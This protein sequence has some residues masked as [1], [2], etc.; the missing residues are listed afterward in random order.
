MKLQKTALSIAILAGLGFAGQTFA[1]DSA[2][3]GNKEADDLDT[4]VVVGI[5]GS[6]EKSQDAKREAKNRIEVV[7]SE[8]IGKM[9]DHN[10]ADSLQRIAGVNISAASANEGAFDEN[11]RVSMRGTSPSFTQ[12]LIDG[13]N[14]GSG[15][16]FVLNQSGTV[17]RSVSYS[18]LPSELVQKV[19]VIKSSEARLVEGGAVGNVNIVTR[20]PLNF[21]DGFTSHI[22]LGAV[23]ANLPGKTDPQLS[24]L[25]NWTN[26]ARSFGFMVQAFSEER[27][28]R[29][30]GQELLGYEQIQRFETDG[31]TPTALSLSNPDLVGVYYPTLIGSALFEQERKRTGGL[32]SAEFKPTDDFKFSLTGFTSRMKA[33]NYNRNYM[34][35]GSRILNRGQRINATTN[36]QAPAPGYVIRNNTLVSATFTP[37][38][39]RQYGIYD[40]ISRPGAESS[41]NFISGDFQW[42]VN[43]SF[44]LSG[45]LGT[46]TGRGKTPTQDVAEWDVGLGS[47][48]GWRLNGVG[49]ADWNLGNTNTGAP[50][51]PGTNINLD[52]IFGFQDVDVVDKERWLKLDG[53]V[54]LDG[55]FTSLQFGLR[56][57]RHE[58][59]LENVVAQGPSFSATPGPFDP[60]TW[61][62]GYRNYPGNFA[63][64]LGGNFPRNIWYYTPEQLA[65]FNRLANRDP[66]T[67]RYFPAEYG[68]DERSTAAYFQANFES[69]KWAGNFGL[70]YVRTDMEAA[71]WV[72]TSATD[73][74]AITTS[75]FG[76]YRQDIVRNVYKDWLPSLN[77]RYSI[78]DNKLLRFALSRTL[79]RPDYS[80]IA[81]AVTLNDSNL[82]GV[83]GNP[84]LEPVLSTNFDATFEWYYGERALLSVSGF[85][86]DIDNYVTFTNINRS[87]FT[88]NSTYPTGAFLNYDVQ[89]YVNSN[90][91][92]RGFE[93]AWEQPF[94]DYFGVFANYTF[95]KGTTDDGYDMLGTSR[96]TYNLGGYFENEHFNARLNYTYRSEFFSGLDR[97]SAFYQD[98]ID[99]VSASFGY[100]FNDNYSIALDALNL[101][102]PKTAYY[103]ENRDRPRSIYQNGRQYYLTFRMKF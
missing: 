23:H 14:I 82:T 89:T 81:G 80:A 19:E 78:D 6:I 36:P 38:A 66:V 55:T 93:V 96:N 28:L 22:S 73:P 91:K 39:T 70:R 31:V 34:L 49:A 99:N 86:M 54:F 75:A 61:P 20:R 57:A 41:S 50:G 35:W 37:E 59:T 2:S 69:E 44:R 83:G 17:G 64:G 30:D 16:W 97:A 43:D 56:D 12:T 11:D 32:V 47:G 71:N 13:H 7:T 51:T 18:L 33:D 21:G 92:V 27:H 84:D 25:A 65:Q 48:A 8:D 46:S 4:V 87:Y 26:D 58:R 53:E 90:A 95:A 62:Q 88:I 9:P 3:A 5:R 42:D 85:L 103:A 10:V 94:G 40:Q 24:A 76:A 15:D 98:E 52:W 67:R 101:N 60:S 74:R 100:K 45:Q 68:L 63:S 102:N 72:N 77:L 29:R 79:T 1:Q